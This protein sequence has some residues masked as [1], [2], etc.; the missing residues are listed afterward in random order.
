MSAG[1]HDDIAKSSHRERST[2]KGGFV[3]VAALVTLVLIALLITGAFFASGQEL[4]VGRNE[5]RD[6]QAFE[7]AEYALTHAIA[8][9]DGPTRESMTVGQ[10]TLLPPVMAEPLESSVFVTKLDT[11]LFLVVAEGHIAASDALDLRRRVGIFIR[12]VVDGASVQ[13]PVRLSEQAWSELY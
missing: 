13:P 1:A 6:Q 9:W 12:S 2:R 11:A 7:F 4:G 10:T 3:L 5:I 8:G